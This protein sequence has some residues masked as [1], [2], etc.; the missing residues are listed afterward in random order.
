MVFVS[1][2]NTPRLGMNRAGMQNAQHPPYINHQLSTTS[3]GQLSR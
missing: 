3:Y 2:Y 1:R